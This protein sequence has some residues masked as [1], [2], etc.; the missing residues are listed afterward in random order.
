MSINFIKIGKKVVILSLILIFLS[1]FSIILKGF[2]FGLEFVGGIEIEIE[3][4]GINDLKIIKNQLF[5]IK[6]LKIRYYGS[7]KCI[8]IKTKLIKNYADLINDIEKSLSNDF[9]IVKINFISAEVNKEIIKNTFNAVFIAFVSMLIYLTFRFKYKFAISA[10]LALFHDIFLILGFISFFNIEFDVVVLS[11]IFAVFGYSINDTVIIFDR[12]RENIELSNTDN[13]LNYL[14]NNAVEKTL[15]RTLIT[16]ISTLLVTVILLFS[17]GTYL[18]SFSLVLSFG[19]II[20]TCSS[21]FIS[22]LPLLY[23][24]DSKIKITRIERKVWTPRH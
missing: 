10:I 22:I 3:A 2:N 6:N 24:Y 15:S 16:S 20:G 8:Q 4:Q 14:I 1:S 17:A 12:I 5:D 23:F 7:K 11:A 21:I 9:K 18:F 13:D 19:I